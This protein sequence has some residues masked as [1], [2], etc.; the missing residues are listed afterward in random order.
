MHKV[1]TDNAI[2]VRH[3]YKTSNGYLDKFNFAATASS[4]TF[5]LK[6]SKKE[7]TLITKN[8]RFKKS[9]HQE[10]LFLITFILLITFNHFQQILTI[11]IFSEVQLILSPAQHQQTLYG[12][13][14]LPGRKLSAR[15]SSIVA[16]V[17]C[18]NKTLMCPRVQP[19]ITTPHHGNG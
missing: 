16:M 14:F 17:V 18:F 8:F 15:R 10:F 9:V 7:T 13:Q 12:K 5:W 1:L 19:C 3:L 6:L 11:S 2:R 4:K